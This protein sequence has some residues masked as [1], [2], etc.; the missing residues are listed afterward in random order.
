[1]ATN[2]R[3]IPEDIDIFAATDYVASPQ[4]TRFHSSNAARR[5]LV[6]GIRSGKT[7]SGAHE[8]LKIILQ[9]C[10]PELAEA[11]RHKL[12]CWVVA[13]TSK[14]LKS[15]YTEIITILELL[16]KAGYPIVLKENP[17]AMNI[18]LIDG[19]FIDFRSG[20]KPA[21]LRSATV[22]ICWVDEGGYLRQEAWYQVCQR[23]AARRGPIIITGTPD[24][25]NWFWEECIEGGMPPE[26]PYGVFESDGGIPRLVS[27]YRTEDFPWYPKEYIADAKKTMPA[28][29]FDK[30]YLAKFNASGS[31][32]F[33]NIEDTFHQIPLS[34]TAIPQN[35]S[36]LIGIDLA[37]KQDF[38]VLVVMDAKGVIWDIERWSGVDYEIQKE[39][40]AQTASKWNDAVCVM[41][42]AN[43]GEAIA[44]SLKAM[45]VRFHKVDMHS[46]QIK[47]D[48]VESMQMALDSKSRAIQIPH[49]KSPFSP[50]PTQILVD[51]MK[52]YE[53]KVTAKGRISY[54]APK[55]LHDDCVIAVCLAYWGKKHG[56]AHG[57]AT[58]CSVALSRDEFIRDG[59]QQERSIRDRMGEPFRRGRR[60]RTVGRLFG[61][62]G[63]LGGGYDGPIWG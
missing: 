46:P 54:S 5:F 38:S 36:F 40:I 56:F 6:W 37:K 15:C 34:K 4:A 28:N 53:A 17:G 42:S 18:T 9:L 39:R 30:D 29:E 45:G 51:E 14:H 8:F 16:E 63:I 2:Y 22:D 58:P 60:R 33:R 55:N 26:A 19:T 10:R 57:S 25:R 1:M 13:P 11:R 43:V 59:E 21:N 3:P 49:P 23:V 20:E 35:V 48:V 12:L 31:A 32:V 44:D 41:D 47:R 27:H 7:F 61:R 24:G 52:A 62:Q 50:E